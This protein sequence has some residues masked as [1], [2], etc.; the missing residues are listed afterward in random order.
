MTIQKYRLNKQHIYS[1]TKLSQSVTTT[2]IDMSIGNSKVVSPRPKEWC[3]L[4]GILHQQNVK[5]FG[6]N[7]WM[8]QQFST[9][10]PILPEAPRTSRTGWMQNDVH[11]R[12]YE[13]FQV[14]LNASEVMEESTRTCY[15]VWSHLRNAIKLWLQVGKIS[16]LLGLQQLSPT[17]FR[18]TWSQTAQEW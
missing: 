13:Y 1:K 9:A 17:W 4:K 14:L 6:S 8:T 16:A 10:T 3:G 15:R 2:C 18:C 7:N 5:W 12:C 11:L